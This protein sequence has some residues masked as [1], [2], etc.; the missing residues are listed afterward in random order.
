MN[1][2]GS[3]LF[4]VSQESEGVIPWFSGQFAYRPGVAYSTK[5]QHAFWNGDAQFLGGFKFNLNHDK[6][7]YKR[8]DQIRHRN[9]RLWTW[10][11]LS[12]CG[13]CTSGSCSGSTST[14]LILLIQHHS[15]TKTY[16]YTIQLHSEKSR[17]LCFGNFVFSV[18]MTLSCMFTVGWCYMYPKRVSLKHG[19]YQGK[20]IMPDE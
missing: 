19:A 15:I 9:K 8:S 6:M 11:R 3:K 14:L 7:S 4:S 17:I 2:N 18:R 10:Y 1:K 12:Q 20:R 5:R 13:K 16:M